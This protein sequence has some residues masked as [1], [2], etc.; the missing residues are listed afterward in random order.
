M[1][2]EIYDGKVCGGNGVCNYDTD[3]NTARCFCNNGFTS[4]NGC[5]P[6]SDSDKGLGGALAGA[7]F[8][9]LALGAL[10]VGIWW[11]MTQRSKPAEFTDDYAYSGSLN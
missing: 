8:G 6:L 11:Y 3:A 10:G 7:A 9:G 2:C 5:R 4:K 1:Q